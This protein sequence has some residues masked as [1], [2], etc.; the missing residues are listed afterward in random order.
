MTSSWIRLGIFCLGLMIWEGYLANRDY[1]VDDFSLADIAVFPL[2]AQLT[3]W[4]GLD[5]S[6]YPNIERWYRNMR[7]RS[8]L[9]NHPYFTECSNTSPLHRRILSKEA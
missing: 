4:L 8:S 1:L 5:L 7:G 3:E 6:D 2:I 9:K